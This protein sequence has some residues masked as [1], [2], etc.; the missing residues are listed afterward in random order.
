[1]VLIVGVLALFAIVW[2]M[3][4]P[5]ARFW[6]LDIITLALIAT[7]FLDLRLTQ[8][9]GARLGWDVLAMGGNAKMVWRMSKPYLPSAL[10]GMAAL[11]GFYT[12][13]RKA[14]QS[15]FWRQREEALAGDRWKT[16]KTVDSTS[17]GASTSLKRGVNERG[18]W[19]AT[20]A[21]LL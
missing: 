4:L 12:I 8:I 11:A 7:A 6:W 19:Y 5:R 1:E 9:M 16:V 20:T 10:V 14:L 21:F 2:R 13:M 3:L 17:G 15:W 18:M